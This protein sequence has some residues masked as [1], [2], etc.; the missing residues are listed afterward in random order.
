MW[1]SRAPAAR[2]A[3]AASRVASTLTATYCSQ[4]P[5]RCTAGHAALRHPGDT[6]HATDV[7]VEVRHGAPAGGGGGGRLGV[8]Q[9]AP[10][11][12]VGVPAEVQ[13]RHGFLAG[14]AA[15]GVG[16]AAQLVVADFLGDRLL[17]DLGSQT[18][19]PRH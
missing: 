11:V 3:W 12:P 4:L 6:C 15:L 5:R 7:A 14:V 8:E 10:Q 13:A 1:T 19:P 16:D 9:E 2:A 17:V 18:R